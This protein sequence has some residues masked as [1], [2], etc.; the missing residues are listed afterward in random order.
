MADVQQKEALPQHLLIPGN[1]TRPRFAE[2]RAWPIAPQPALWRLAEYGGDAAPN[3]P[4]DASTEALPRS[5]RPTRQT[6]NPNG[7]DHIY[8][9]NLND[10]VAVACRAEYASA[11]SPGA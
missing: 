8:F 4:S 7:H 2:R 5:P 1:R 6:S 10:A 11:R 3:G 9:A